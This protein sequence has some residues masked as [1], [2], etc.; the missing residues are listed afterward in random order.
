MSPRSSKGV[1]T[2]LV[3]ALL[4]TAV[5]AP[6]ASAH[7]GRHIQHRQSNLALRLTG[8]P[9]AVNTGQQVTYTATVVNTGHRTD[10][11]AGFKDWIPGGA[12]FVSAS[13]SQGGCSGNPVVTCNLGSLAR[14]AS[15]AVTIVVT[16]NQAGQMTDVGWVSTNP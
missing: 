10:G 1:L 6:L 2:G 9:G 4:A 16:A 11:S 8:S 7:H 14:G 5:A 3:L 12:S 13:A 15:A